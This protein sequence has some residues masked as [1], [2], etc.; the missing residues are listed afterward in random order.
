MNSS[1]SAFVLTLIIFFNGIS[2]KSQVRWINVDDE[3]GPLP[4]SIHVYRTTDSLDGKPNIA[5][6]LEADLKDRDL[7][8]LTDTSLNRRLTPSEFYL[9]KAKLEFVHSFHF[10]LVVVNTT[11]FSFATNR[12]LNVVI[13]NKEL[14]GYNIHSFPG[15]GKDTFTYRHVIPA[16]IGIKKNRKAD[17]AWIYTDS[18][19]KSAYALQSPLEPFRDSSATLELPLLKKKTREAN[20]SRPGKW[21]VHAAVGGGPVLVQAGEVM[22]TNNQ[23]NRFAGKAIDDRH[24]RTA[25]GYTGD[26][27]LIILVTEGR[28]PGRAE[29]ASLRHLAEMLK[30]IGCVEALNLDGGGS[31]CLLINGKN[32]IRPSDREGQQRPIPGVFLIRKK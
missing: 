26:N 14:V 5:Y 15:R 11:F 3:F 17:V 13:T 28:N 29:G 8:F 12:N 10:P 24:P 1:R 19:R 2:L 18:L 9:K 20:L 31:S 25:M 30:E 22:I 23:E 21:K 32:T 16:A 4:S 6:Y 27:K 7:L